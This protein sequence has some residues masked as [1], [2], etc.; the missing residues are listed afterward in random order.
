MALFLFMRVSILSIVILQLSSFLLTQMVKMYSLYTEFQAQKQHDLFT[1]HE[2]CSNNQM[3]SSLG[4]ENS[5]KLCEE[6]KSRL[7]IDPLTKAI[8]QSL[9]EIYLCG[10]F[11]CSDYLVYLSDWRI[12]VVCIVVVRLVYMFFNLYVDTSY[13]K[14]MLYLQFQNNQHA[15]KEYLLPSH[16]NNTNN[17]FR[18]MNYEEQYD[19]VN[20]KKIM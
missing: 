15:K 6:T 11:S 18:Q 13:K 16:F 17:N 8:K 14:Q 7:Q 9:S 12:L 3:I 10:T 4:A 1:F 19:F 20:H 2:I 5:K